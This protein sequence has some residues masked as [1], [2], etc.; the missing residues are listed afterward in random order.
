[1]ATIYKTPNKRWIAAIR[2]KNSPSI[3]KVFD[4]HSDAKKWAL[5]EEQK[6]LDKKLLTTKKSFHE[7]LAKFSTEIAP[8]YKS[9]KT[10]LWM[11]GFIKKNTPN[12]KLSEISSTD[13][14]GYRDKRLNSG[15]SGSSINKELNLLSR[16]FDIAIKEWQWMDAPNPIKQ[17]TRPKNG[18]HRQRRPTPK[19]LLRLHE[20]CLRSGNL[21]V[22]RMIEL[23]I[24]TGMRQGELLS[25]TQDA[26]DLK[27]RVA[28]LT[29]TK[30]G[31]D[32]DVPL[33]QKVCKL[34]SDQIDDK[35]SDRIFSNWRSGDGFR[36]TYRRIC[37]RANIDDLRFHDLRHEA[38]SRLFEK[39]LNQFQV[40]AI[41]GHRS[42]QSL[43]RYT[44]LKANYLVK[45]LD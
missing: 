26:I 9:K 38:A 42:L 41:T 34:F 22:W 40:A 43:Q 31:D 32:R 1:M 29:D 16:V 36:S 11:L 25:L 21:S 20:E 37:I 17:V 6:L 13:I 45:L 39:G 35:Q 27:S 28:H 3:S 30:N 7:L 24:E 18:K 33:S 10:T 12:F 15:V 23:A 2:R 14:C 44:H 4:K 19:E 5:I 8:S